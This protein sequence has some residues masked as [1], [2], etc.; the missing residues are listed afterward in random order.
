MN[1][2][3]RETSTP[4]LS[5]ANDIP[6]ELDGRLLGTA[7]VLSQTRTCLGRV[8]EG[9]ILAGKRSGYGRVRSPRFPGLV[10]PLPSRESVIG[11]NLGLSHDLDRYL[12]VPL[13]TWVLER[14]EDPIFVDGREKSSHGV[15]F[16]VNSQLS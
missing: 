13:E 15:W 7:P 16:L 14:T 3:I 9:V 1:R 2:P 8:S 12:L 6:Q 5:T 11:R 4:E 10:D